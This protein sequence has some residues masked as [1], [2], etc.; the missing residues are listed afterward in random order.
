MSDSKPGTTRDRFVDLALVD[1]NGNVDLIEI[2]RPFDDVLLSK[3]PYRDNFVPTKSLSGT[4]TTTC[5]AGSITQSHHCNVEPL[6]GRTDLGGATGR[7][8]SR[9][10]FLERM[11]GKLVPW[12]ASMFGKV[13]SEC[14]HQARYA[15]LRFSRGDSHQNVPICPT[16]VRGLPLCHI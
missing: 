13:F 4:I 9:I 10:G 15:A 3:T 11:I 16:R 14:I 8:N 1:A 6:K 12:H 2:K 7:A 5:Y